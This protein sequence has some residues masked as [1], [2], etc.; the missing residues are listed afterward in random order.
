MAYRGTDKQE[1]F[2]LALARGMDA[3][4]AAK[5]ADYHDS[6]GSHRS[7]AREPKVIARVAELR[8]ELAVRAALDGL[9]HAQR[10]EAAAAKLEAGAALA[11]AEAD[12]ARLRGLLM[13][14]ARIRAMVCDRLTRAADRASP[15]P[16]A[17]AAAGPAP[18][19]P[20][21]PE[22]DPEAFAPPMPYEE[23]RARFAPRDGGAARE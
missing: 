10:L 6:N 23:W 2:A 20:E 14:A 22:D 15:R 7:R 11:A 3:V 17:A 19:S 9:D 8:R 13:D 5:A 16:A 21:R 4:A 12:L 1:A 18:A